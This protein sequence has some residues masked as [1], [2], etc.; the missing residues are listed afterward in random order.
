M[1]CRRRQDMLFLVYWS[2]LQEIKIY[3]RRKCPVGDFRETEIP[4]W[5]ESEKVPVQPSY[6][7]RCLCDQVTCVWG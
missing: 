3:T 7:D 2:K 4:V 5:P 1:R 6:L